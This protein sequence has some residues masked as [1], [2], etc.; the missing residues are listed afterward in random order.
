MNLLEDLKDAAQQKLKGQVLLLEKL[1]SETEKKYQELASLLAELVKKRIIVPKL[2][3]VVKEAR[4]Y[5][6]KVDKEYEENLEWIRNF[7][8]QYYIGT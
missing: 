4:E 3:P 2:L 5:W 8:A 7:L 6:K 1:D